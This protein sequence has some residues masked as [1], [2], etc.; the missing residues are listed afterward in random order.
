MERT[1]I[2]KELLD[3]KQVLTQKTWP[4]DQT[5]AV[6]IVASSDILLLI[7]Y[8]EN[9]SA[10]LARKRTALALVNQALQ[11]LDVVYAYLASN[12]TDRKELLDHICDKLL[13]S[14]DT[15]LLASV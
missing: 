1:A 11:Q 8:T 3:L 15:L 12:Y 6:L 4:L 7:E 14:I 2:Q 10:N 5:I 9:T 13:Q